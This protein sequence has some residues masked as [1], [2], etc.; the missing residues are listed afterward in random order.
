MVVLLIALTKKRIMTMKNSNPWEDI[1]KPSDALSTRQIPT[2][3]GLRLFY[4]KD[5]FGDYLFIFEF[6]G[7]GRSLVKKHFTRMKGLSFDL[8]KSSVAGEQLLVLMLEDSAFVDVF[9]RLCDSIVGLLTDIE[10]SMTGLAATLLQIKKWQAFMDGTR[11]NR[12]SAEQVR[13]LF[14]ELVYLQRLI[15]LKGEQSGVESWAGPDRDEQ[16]FIFGDVCVEIKSIS[17]GQRNRVRISSEDQL[18]TVSTDLFLRIYRLVEE[19]GQGGARS[20]NELVSDIQRTVFDLTVLDLLHEKLL[21]VGYVELEEYDAPT[22]RIA[23]EMTFRVTDQFPRIV[24]SELSPGVSKVSYE[25]ALESIESF[26][27]SDKDIRV[28]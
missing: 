28:V 22:F 15:D 25:I 17:G 26:K 13:G 20:L 18:D 2:N 14:C 3:R 12:L 21:Q 5:P 9:E 8:R 10:D 7:D 24:R 16:D 6:E 4:A 19:P 27:C 1:K 23:E 11:G